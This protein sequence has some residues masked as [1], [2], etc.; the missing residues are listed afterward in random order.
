LPADELSLDVELIQNR[1]SESSELVIFENNQP[2]FVIMTMEQYE[3]YIVRTVP[4]SSD[5]RTSAA[6]SKLKIGR[7]VQESLRRL[8]Y[9]DILPESEILNLTSPEYSNSVFGLNFP[10]LKKYEPTLAFEDQKRDANGYNRY[11]NFTLSHK[12]TQIFALQ[13]VDSA[14]TSRTLEIWL[15][16]WDD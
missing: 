11:Y 2:Q 12:S 8:F 7:L 3:A 9:K 13:S 16:Q 1:L 15:Q 5:V 6:Q 10:V 14:V 4:I